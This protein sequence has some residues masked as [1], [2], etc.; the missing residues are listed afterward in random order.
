MTS[1]LGTN[2]VLHVTDGGD[3]V[4]FDGHVRCIDLAAVDVDQLAVDDYQIGR[5]V[6]PGDVDQ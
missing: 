5:D 4:P 6:A 1:S 2:G 3:A